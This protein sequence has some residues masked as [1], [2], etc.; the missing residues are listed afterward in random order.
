M[1]LK[2]ANGNKLLMLFISLKTVKKRSGG[3]KKME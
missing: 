1:T 3:E 2:S